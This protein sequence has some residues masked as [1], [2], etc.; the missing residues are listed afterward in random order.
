MVAYF[1]LKLLPFP[2]KGEIEKHLLQNDVIAKFFTL[3]K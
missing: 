3:N 1:D 2:M